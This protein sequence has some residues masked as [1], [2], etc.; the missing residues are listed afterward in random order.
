V[1]DI[2]RTSAGYTVAQACGH[3]RNDPMTHDIVLASSGCAACPGMPSLALNWVPNAARAS[4]M[5]SAASLTSSESSFR[6]EAAAA[7]DAAAWVGLVAGFSRG[8]LLLA[9]SSLRSGS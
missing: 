7:G 3:T 8:F 4:A 6:L 2:D 5:P 9:K 1:V